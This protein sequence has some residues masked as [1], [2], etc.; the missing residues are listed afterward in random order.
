MDQK[1]KKNKG[2]RQCVQPCREGFPPD[3]LKDPAVLSESKSKTM[4]LSSSM[5]DVTWKRR[6]EKT[7][8][9]IFH[10]TKN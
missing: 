5:T 8:R 6:R 9:E 4:L 1:I 3:T 7:W 2:S 10:G